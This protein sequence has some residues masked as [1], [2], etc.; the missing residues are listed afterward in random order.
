MTLRRPS[1]DATADLILE[2]LE[3]RLESPNVRGLPPDE[4]V[5]VLTRI[6]DALRSKIEDI[7]TADED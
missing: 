2:E 3:E 5:V 6:V 1:V 4:R 7:E